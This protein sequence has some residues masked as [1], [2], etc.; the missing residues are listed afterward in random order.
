MK[1]QSHP[2]KLGERELHPQ[3]LQ[4]IKSYLNYVSLSGGLWV[5]RFQASLHENILGYSLRLI[6]N[7]ETYCV[8]QSTFHLLFS[9]SERETETAHVFDGL[10]DLFCCFCLQVCERRYRNATYYYYSCT[11]LHAYRY[12]L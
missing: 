1:S 7:L 10:A 9:L 8:Q 6:S 11:S 5:G 3:C 4:E 12:I 2:V